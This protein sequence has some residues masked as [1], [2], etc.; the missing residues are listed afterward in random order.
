M[1]PC[2]FLTNELLQEARSVG[3]RTKAL[4]AAKTSKSA[5]KLEVKKTEQCKTKRELFCNENLQDI[6]D[7]LLDAE[8]VSTA[9]V[10]T[11]EDGRIAA[12]RAEDHEADALEDAILADENADNF[13]EE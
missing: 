8:E 10:S 6:E 1:I 11:A 5:T 7:T 9:E 4:E 13:M 3:E 2:S 12:G